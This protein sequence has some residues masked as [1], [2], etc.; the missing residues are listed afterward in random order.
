MAIRHN[1]FDKAT[2]FTYNFNVKIFFAEYILVL[3]YKGVFIM[4]QKQRILTGDRPTG[5]LHIGH[6]VG[7]LQSRVAMQ[8]DYETFI[9]IADI[10]APDYET[11]M[12]ILRNLITH[13]YE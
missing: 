4:T 9:L 6:Y 8:D 7:S 13:R 2:V 1:S 12:A 3:I 5:K 11:R 10:Q